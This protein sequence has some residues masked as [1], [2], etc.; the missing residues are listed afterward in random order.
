MK[1]MF[2]L[3]LGMLV[4]VL[5]FGMTV[6]GCAYFKESWEAASAEH[7]AKKTDGKGGTIH[8]KVTSGMYFVKNPLPGY[9]KTP[10]TSYPSAFYSVKIA[11]GQA[12]QFYSADEDGMYTVYYRAARDGESRA[13]PDENTTN[14]SSK[15]VYVSNDETFTVNI[16]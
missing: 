7:E 4:M 2:K 1:N 3:W 10:S 16:P 5:V 9:E 14:W 15:S 11:A 13:L 12:G 6:V 8:V